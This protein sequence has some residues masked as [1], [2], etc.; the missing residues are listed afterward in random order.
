MFE[1]Y[2]YFLV[3]CEELNITRA[4]KKLYVTHQ[5]LSRYLKNLEEESTMTFIWS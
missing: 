1:N 4:A 2:R 5:C 3:L